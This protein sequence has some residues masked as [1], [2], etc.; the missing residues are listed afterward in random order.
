MAVQTLVLT[1]NLILIYRGNL[2]ATTSSNIADEPSNNAVKIIGSDINT[3]RLKINRQGLIVG[4]EE[5]ATSGGGGSGGIS[6]LDA[7]Y[8]WTAVLKLRFYLS[9]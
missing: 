7:K 4:F 9:N 1:Q 8:K 5:V 6:A 2:R 3:P